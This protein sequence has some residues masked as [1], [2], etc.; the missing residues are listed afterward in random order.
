MNFKKPLKFE[1]LK[2]VKIQIPKKP[3]FDYQKTTSQI[4]FTEL[5]ESLVKLTFDVKQRN[6]NK[7]RYSISN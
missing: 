3:L 4:L 6:N 7:L 5:S 1:S 2:N